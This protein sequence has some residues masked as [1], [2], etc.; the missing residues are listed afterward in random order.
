MIPPH[1]NRIKEGTPG[2]CP[3]LASLTAAI[4][5][6][7]SSANPAISSLGAQVLRAEGR[8]FF[9]PGENS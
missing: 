6:P 7:V 3:G 2:F 5:A 9:R 4:G 1:G 8:L